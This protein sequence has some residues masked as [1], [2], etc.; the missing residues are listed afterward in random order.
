MTNF[1]LVCIE[2]FNGDNCYSF[3]LFYLYFS[4]ENLILIEKINTF[5]LIVLLVW[6]SIPVIFNF[7][8]IVLLIPI[9]NLLMIF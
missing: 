7:Y 4:Y 9:K 3:A 2:I 5:A 6:R 8:G 1:L